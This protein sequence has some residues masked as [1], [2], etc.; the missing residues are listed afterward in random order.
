MII[1]PG[2]DNHWV[3][4]TEELFAANTLAEAQA[5]IR[6]G[7]T[8][9]LHHSSRTDTVRFSSFFVSISFNPRGFCSEHFLI[10]TNV[11]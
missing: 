4:I 6:S 7:I 5:I 10:E 1:Y 9:L 3:A 8:G 11:S 2:K